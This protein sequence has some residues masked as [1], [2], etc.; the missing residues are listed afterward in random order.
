MTTSLIIVSN[1]LPVSVKKV[2][3]KLEFYPSIGGLA[4]GLASYATDKKNKWIGWP[5][6][7]SEEVTEKEKQDIATELGKHNCYPVFLTKK[8]LEDYYNGY[9]NSIL[10][11][12]FHD[13][14]IAVAATKKRDEYWKAY[15]K[16]NAAF[17]DAA[18][19]LSSKGNTIW[20]HDYQLL[21]LPALLRKERTDDR[22]GFFLHIPF[23]PTETFKQLKY[24]DA[25]VAGMLG[26]DLIGF[27]TDGY[28]QNFLSTAQHYD[29]G[30]IDKKKVILQGRVA[31]V[32]DFPMGID[33]EKFARAVKLRA[34][35]TELAKLRI[36]YRGRKL[37]LT[38][39]RLDPTK[40]LVERAA[41]YKEFLVR[42]PQMRGKVVMAML[43]VPSRTDIDE[44]KK[45]KT[46]LET[47][48]KDINDTFGSKHWQPLD[49]MYRSVPFEQ[50]TA[51]YQ[52]AD[53][54]FIVPLRDGM[55]L[56]AKEYLASQPNQNGV[57]VLSKTAGAAEELKDAIM[58]DP[59]KPHT[60]VKGLSRALAMP[61]KELKARVSSMQDLIS[62]S[63]VQVWAGKFMK[64]LKQTSGLEVSR[65]HSLSLA[66][67][68][69][70]IA[71][72]RAANS[73]TLFL[74]YD[75]VLMPFSD[76]PE[77][78]KPTKE[79]KSLLKKLAN[80]AKVVIISGRSR[81][82]LEAWLGDLPVALVA[83]HGAFSRDADKKRWS[84][85]ETVTEWKQP[86]LSL[87]EKYAALTPGA[88]VEEKESALVWHY[89]K[90]KPYYAQ[91]YLVILKRL[92][93]PLARRYN[94]SVHQGNMILEVN[95]Q[96]IHKGR[97]ASKRLED[98]T[99][100]V[101]AIGDDYTDEDMFAALPT[102]TITIKVGRG[103]TKARYR[104]KNVV[105][106]QDLLKKLRT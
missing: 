76:K 98:K 27:H 6:V 74:D 101:L 37:I 9:S 69:A 46:K 95:P 8:Q 91:K 86:V 53:V 44:Y 32:T 96:N 7:S 40:G 64:S 93:A 28:V 17:A 66:R 54:A 70:I 68:K 75:G 33:Y 48:V 72:F 52:R 65:T 49:Y 16:V 24:G 1:R 31:R 83:E 81:T 3:G 21:L 100:F 94:L 88:F 63:T 39:D 34:V 47:L 20:V 84:T 60:L 89:R 11:P 90:A 15:R 103:R 2:D 38:V 25:L 73:H 19:A 29:V 55:N 59:T 71:A 23:P 42:N 62:T 80:S 12:L 41:A 22:I 92:L 30:V 4:T 51:L 26:A 14:P 104:A 35:K 18:L 105:A 5:G 50:L 61:E 77:K 45:L 85:L 78:A 106:V 99:E 87:L 97:A 36:K 58:V 10:W 57:L 102:H 43:A 79:L 56:V 67:Q 82:D 13:V